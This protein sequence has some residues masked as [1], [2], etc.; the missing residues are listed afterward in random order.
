MARF[1]YT[2]IDAQGRERRGA[3]VAVDEGA[4]RAGLTA[5]RLLPV[6]LTVERIANG[7]TGAAR[8]EAVASLTGVSR[9][10]LTGRQR[11]IMTRQLATLIDAA[12]PVDEALAMTAA[13]QDDA[14]ARRIIRDVHAG[15]MEGQRLAE[16]MGQHPKSFTGLYRAAVAG[17]E[18]AGRLGHTLN[19]LADY[20]HKAEK[21]R[22]KIVTASIYP[23]AL[24]TVAFSVVCALMIFVVPTLA[25][26]FTSLGQ[27]LPLITRVLIGVSLFL[28]RF[29]PFLLAALALSAV[30]F[31]LASRQP[32]VRL[33]IDGFWLRAPLVGRR[34]KEINA[35]RFVRAVSLLVGAGAP[36]LDSVRASRDAVDN[37]VVRHAIV[38]MGE[39]IEQG[40]PL[41]RAMRASLVF[42]TMTAY[43]AASGENAG[44]LPGMLERA[45][46]QLDQDVEAFTDGALSLLEPAIIVTMGAMVAGI[47]LAIMLPILE[48]NRMALG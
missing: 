40:E 44:E 19:Q 9:G 24:V 12:V 26:Q 15:V 45:A 37:L 8:A 11:L 39:A 29:W 34:V 32:G 20:L 31:A 43:M 13:Q 2:A 1:A 4:A 5:K 41:S 35:S 46:D 18:R 10:K 16:A 7:S 14:S 36:V 33:G 27:E 25:Q 17:A 3:I 42:P 22:Q 47:V 21:I 48:L 30:G 28:S 6:Q 38:G 23:M